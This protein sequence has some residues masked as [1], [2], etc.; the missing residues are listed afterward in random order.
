M[1]LVN[2]HIL[3]LLGQLNAYWLWALR[4]VP[5][6]DSKHSRV[7]KT[8]HRCEKVKM[9]KLRLDAEGVELIKISSPTIAAGNRVCEIFMAWSP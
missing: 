1:F 9:A 4:L 7:L 2:Q 5:R 3:Q 8:M 6:H